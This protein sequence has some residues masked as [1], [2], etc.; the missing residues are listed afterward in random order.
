MACLILLVLSG[1]SPTQATRL[2]EPFAPPAYVKYEDT[3]FKFALELEASSDYLARAWYF[4]VGLESN[5]LEKSEIT[6]GDRLS[7]DEKVKYD[8]KTGAIKSRAVDISVDPVLFEGEFLTFEIWQDDIHTE[9]FH[10]LGAFEYGVMPEEDY[11]MLYVSGNFVPVTSE[12][13]SPFAAALSDY[14][15]YEPVSPS[16]PVPEPAS[17]VLV[18]VGMIGIALV[19]KRPKKLIS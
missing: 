10:F 19:R 8:K 9:Q 4:D 2:N 15:P 3:E 18:G 12:Q 5:A 14:N 7:V 6:A 17:L 11:Q 16:N 13:F 1:V